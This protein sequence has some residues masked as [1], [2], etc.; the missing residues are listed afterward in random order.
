MSLSQSDSRPT[1]TSYA[2][3][4]AWPVVLLFPRTGLGF[5]LCFGLLY[6]IS[7]ILQIRNLVTLIKTHTHTNMHCLPDH[8]VAIKK[9]IH[10]SFLVAV[11]LVAANG[12]SPVAQDND[13]WTQATV[14]SITLQPRKEKQKEFTR[15]CYGMVEIPIYFLDLFLSTAI[16]IIALNHTKVCFN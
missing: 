14:D 16:N 7:P 3:N 11:D 5:Q 1:N 15:K 12:T 9:N 10:A 4:L 6:Y 2:L 13:P 8:R